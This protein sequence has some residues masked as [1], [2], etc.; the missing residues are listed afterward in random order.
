MGQDEA[1]SQQQVN[2][3][4]VK[5]VLEIAKKE[6]EY[7]AERVKSIDTR[8]S[9]FLTVSV[10]IFALV[11]NAV[12]LPKGLSISLYLV[13]FDLYTLIFLVQGFAIYLFAKTL[14]TKDF[15]RYDLTGIVK[16]SLMS[17]AAEEVLP[18]IAS[19]ISHLINVNN[20]VTAEK[21]RTY[22][23]GIRCLEITVLLIGVTMLI[24]TA[25]SM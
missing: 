7:E 20:P 8:T 1:N 6:Y 24:I 15:Q 10:A 17:R 23:L 14:K 18:E 25:I 9:T 5:S 12:R 11:A 13:L 19:T 22:N 4:T 16:Y 21:I 2:M 3:E